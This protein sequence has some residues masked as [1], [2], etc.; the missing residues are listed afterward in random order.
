MTRR[1]W[2]ADRVEGDH[3][4]LLGQ[5]A[6]HL[7][8]VLRAEAGQQFDVAANGVVRLGTI[9]SATV[10]KVEFHLGEEVESE[11][12][13]EIAVYL[14]IFKFDRMEWA[15][16]K[17]TE[18]GVMRVVP[19][20]ASRSAHHLV[21]AADARVERWRKIVR[22]AAQQARRATPPDVATPIE[23]KTALSGKEESRILL[24]EGEEALSLKAA[25]AGKRPPLALAFGPEGG[26]TSEELDLFAATGWTSASL[27]HTVLRAETAAIAAASVAFAELN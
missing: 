27:G 24:A 9:M 12:L 1:R 15:L 17:L 16:E 18:L 11:S 10:D 7:F 14:S 21:K 20:I 13:P 4:F 3:A 22:E 19:V 6:N 5:N 8:R 25:L 2:I 26:W 23:L